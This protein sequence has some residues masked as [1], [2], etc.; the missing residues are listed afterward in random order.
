MP[1]PCTTVRATPWYRGRLTHPGIMT[2]LT[3]IWNTI[4]SLSTLS[5]HIIIS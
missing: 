1:I 5:H 3:G 4:F 2:M